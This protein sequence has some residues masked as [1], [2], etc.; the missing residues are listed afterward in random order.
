[1][2]NATTGVIVLVVLVGGLLL[3]RTAAKSAAAEAVYPVENASGWFSRHVFSRVRGVFARASTAAENE[4]LRR[5]VAVLSM[6]RVD[7]DT[8][9]A[10]NA[11]LRALL[12]YAP[13]TTNAWLVAPV[14]ARGGAADVRRTLRAGRGSL[15]GVAEDDVVAAPD[16][17][18]GRVSAVSPHTAEI[19]LVTDP[20]SHVSCRLETIDPDLGTVC[21]VVSGGGVR[22]VDD[23]AAGSLLYVVDPLRIRH[24]GRDLQVPPRTKVVT[25]GLGGVFPAGLAVGYL[26]ETRIDESK[27]AREGDVVPAVDF[28]SLED[29]FI[30]HAQ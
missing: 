17:L 12:G 13:G 19:L 6:A 14:L 23:G 30:R 25:S 21:G 2:K 27:L 16:G 11:R 22:A 8:A 26:L 24:L 9:Q 1:M 18:V 5:E 3:W 4:R 28:N 10:E 29:V 15:D 7:A 20:S